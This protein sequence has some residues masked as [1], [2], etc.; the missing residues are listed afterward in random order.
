MVVLVG[1]W[2]SGVLRLGRC[3][4]GDGVVQLLLLMAATWA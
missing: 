4:D 1:L 2:V 3:A